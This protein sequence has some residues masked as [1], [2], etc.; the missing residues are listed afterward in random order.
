MSTFQKHYDLALAKDCG[1][2][3]EKLVSDFDIMKTLMTKYGAIEV[4]T[5]P[6]H[7]VGFHPPRL[8]TETL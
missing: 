2:Q 6:P 1:G 4:E 8:V 3:A 7:L 5:L